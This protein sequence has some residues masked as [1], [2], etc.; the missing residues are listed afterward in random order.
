MSKETKE[1]KV[2]DVVV[3]KGMISPE[4]TVREIVAGNVACDWFNLTGKDC[5]ILSRESFLIEELFYVGG[6]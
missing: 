3:L 5:Y 1:L 6:K 2:G 4:M